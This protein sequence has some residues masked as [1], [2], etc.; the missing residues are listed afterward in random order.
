MT[1]LSSNKQCFSL[2]I[3][4]LFV[5]C[6]WNLDQKLAEVHI[7]RFGVIVE[8]SVV[9]RTE[10]RKRIHSFLGIPYGTSQRFEKPAFI[11]DDV[12]RVFHADKWV[13]CVQVRDN[14]IQSSQ[15]IVVSH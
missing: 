8:S 13:D 14:S 10:G 9:L 15:S 1:L 7:E 5:T 3:L 2:L 12:E 11:R 4:L 6:E